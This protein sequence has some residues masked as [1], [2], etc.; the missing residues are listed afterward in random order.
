M[1]AEK[2]IVVYQPHLVFEYCR[3]FVRN[4]VVP[5]SS[6]KPFEAVLFVEAPLQTRGE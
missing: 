2:L 5:K 6:P 3:S 4:Y 1:K